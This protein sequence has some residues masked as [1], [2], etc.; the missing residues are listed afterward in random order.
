MT[1]RKLEQ[2]GLSHLVSMAR[3]R[4]AS[5]GVNCRKLHLLLSDNSSTVVCSTWGG[6]SVEVG[7]QADLGVGVVYLGKNSWPELVGVNGNKAVTI[8]EKENPNVDAII[9]L[10]GSIV[11]PDFRC[12]RVRVWVDKYDIVGQVPQIG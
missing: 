9:V 12:D 1:H 6:T 4:I 10:I 8:I 7:L 2:M 3:K 11:T 5:S